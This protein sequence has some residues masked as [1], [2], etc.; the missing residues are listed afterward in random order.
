MLNLL[1]RYDVLCFPPRSSISLLFSLHVNCPA[2]AC[3]TEPLQL[4][5]RTSLRSAGGRCCCHGGPCAAPYSP[6]IDALQLFPNPAL[7]FD[8]LPPFNFFSKGNFRPGGLCFLS[9]SSV[10]RRLRDNIAKGCY[11]IY[12]VSYLPPLGVN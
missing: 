2:A 9:N 6:C 10:H 1:C 12:F 5:H 4:C 7:D 11:W 3:C 8:P